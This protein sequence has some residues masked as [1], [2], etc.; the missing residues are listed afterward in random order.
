V[1]AQLDTLA[2]QVR[3]DGI[4]VETK[5]AS[6]FGDA[7]VV[8]V[9]EK[10][11]ADLAVVGTHGRTGL[12]RVLLG[13][14]AE[15]VVRLCSCNVL[16][17]RDGEA[18]V[19]PK[20]V[21]V[22]TDFSDTAESGVRLALAISAPDAE[23]ELLHCWLPPYQGGGDYLPAW[24]QDDL[25]A[26]GIAR[27]EALLK[28]HGGASQTIRYA[29]RETTPTAGIQKH[30]ES[31]PFDAVV[32][33]SHGRRGI[34]RMLLGSVAEQTVRYASVPVYVAHAEPDAS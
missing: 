24:M 7:A 23:V 9:A 26:E 28:A 33:G 27:G 29:Q 32:I 21:L 14:V 34:R 15:R 11:D 10:V 12:D 2:E 13:S 8:A 4:E 5:L 1:G 3:G 30:L 22:P 25:K 31:H 19:P 6:E 17:A 16:V 20:R 18:A